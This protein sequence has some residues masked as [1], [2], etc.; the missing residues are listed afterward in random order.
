MRKRSFS[1]ILPTFGR[2]KEVFEF[3]DSVL[4]LDYDQTLI[5]VI[6][7]DQN[8]VINLADGLL[9]YTSQLNIRHV[10]VDIKGIAHAKNVGIKMSTGEIITFADDDSTYYPDT[11][12]QANNC[13]NQRAGTDIFYGKVFD[14]STQK[15]VIRNWKPEPVKINKFNYHLNY[16]AIA[17]FTP[18]KD[19]YFD[20]RFGVGTR[21]GVGEELDYLLQALDRKYEVWYT[22]EI[23]VWHPDASVF[24]MSKEKIF[25]Y[26]RGYGAI[27]RKHNGW[28]MGWNLLISTGYQ[29]VMMILLFCCLKPDGAKRRYLAFAGRIKGYL[30][31]G[32][33]RS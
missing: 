32:R 10:K 1:I 28:I 14:R 5:E 33:E 7:V 15:N 6:I 29:F 3:L 22:P 12:T 4:S 31:F 24:A 11:I 26:A 2:S 16:I 20:E 19:L 13:F 23:E 17:C 25:Y 27:C 8:D 21:Y 9:P 18:V 30:E